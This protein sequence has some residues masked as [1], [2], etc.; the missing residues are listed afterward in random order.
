MPKG[1]LKR[2]PS[3]AIVLS[4]HVRHLTTSLGAGTSEELGGTEPQVWL[5]PPR[6][7]AGLTG[8]G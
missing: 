5:P 1:N 8:V 6:K 7:G 2:T 3:L 4:V